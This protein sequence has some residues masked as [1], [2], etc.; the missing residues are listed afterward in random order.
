MK[1]K[2]LRGKGR[3]SA[4][5]SKS[6]EKYRLN[7][8]ITKIPMKVARSLHDFQ[9]LIR[10]DLTIFTTPSNEMGGTEKTK[11]IGVMQHLK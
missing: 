4:K 9:T 1:E 2:T 8:K 3:R 10:R 7:K 11:K 5:S 6:Q